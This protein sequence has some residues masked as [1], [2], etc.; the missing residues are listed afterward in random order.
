MTTAKPRVLVVDD[1]DFV[2]ES[3]IEVLLGEGFA[4]QGASTGRD[5]ARLVGAQ[6]FDVV[7]TDLRMPGGDGMTVLAEIKKQRPE[8]PVIVLTG[9]GTIDKAVL[10]IKGG[11]YDFVQKPVEA[12]SL[13]RL[14]RRAHEHRSLIAE[15][16]EL[17]KTVG[18]LRDPGFLVGVSA[19]HR[20]L[21]QQIDQVAK[22]QATVLIT[23]ESG[24][25]KE[26]VALEIHRRSQRADKNLVCVNC[27]AVTDSLFESEFFGHRRGSFTSA[28]ADRA[29]RFAEAHGGTLVLDEIGTLKLEMQAK[30]L[31]V[32]ET[33]EYQVVGDSTTQR[34]DVRVIAVTNEDLAAAVREGHFRPDLFYRLN[35][36]PIE[37]PPIRARKEDLVPIAE[38]LLM[39]LR[40]ANP[41]AGPATASLRLA[42]DAVSV[43]YA[44]D[45]PGNV[46]ELRNVLER[47]L[48]MS[49]VDGPDARVFRDIL[50]TQPNRPTAPL[51]EELNLR[52]RTDALEKELIQAAL[53]RTGGK[54]RE[55]SGLLGI[56]PRNLG[57]YLRK[58]GLTESR[59]DG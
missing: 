22:S 42:A 2:R 40:A 54:K 50:L 23:G 16:R 3:T 1:E 7:V 30:L 10:A 34:A 6:E 19:A 44:Y 24:T 4:V 41:L 43:L 11:A 25:G 26:L 18:S 57:Y 31:R 8:L 17:R 13:V 52:I 53:L 36:F 45:W 47:A 55:A 58:H 59:A 35:I 33:G 20:R 37:V 48:L 14:V 56:D 38:H 29:G 46:R 28:V 27:A 39:C 49:G 32:L 5:A 12:E 15:V 51:S 21:M 9:V